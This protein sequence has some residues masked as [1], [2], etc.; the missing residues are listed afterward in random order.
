MMPLDGVRVLDLTRFLSGPYC[1]MTLGDMGAEVVKVERPPGGDDIRKLG[2]HVNGESYCFAMV[3]RNKRSVALDVS[4]DAGREVLLT[5]AKRA[6]VVVENFRPGVTQRLGIDPDTLRAEHPELVHCSITG[7]GQDGPYRDRPG[8]DI[9]AQGICGF[10]RMTGHPG[11]RPAKVGIAINDL[12]AGATAVQAV[13]AAYIHR[14]RTGTGQHIDVSLVDAGLAMTVWEAAAYF[15]SG[16]LP[17]QTGTR[18]RR[19]APYQAFRSADGYVT[20]GG[21]TEAMW[22]ALCLEVLESPQ[23]LA[24]PRYADKFLRL[25]HVDELEADIEQVTSTRTTA[26]WVGRLEAAGVPGG[27]V[28]TYD[29]TLVDEHVLARGAVVEMEHPRMGTIRGL[30]PAARLSESPLSVRTPAPLLGEHTT[31]VLVDHGYR[32]EEISSLLASGTILQADLGA[33]LG[34][35][36]REAIS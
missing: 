18:H 20:V 29:Q 2:P 23:L 7:F 17:A 36:E 25:A 35:P 6:D 4:T 33:D 21:N 5:L 28:L 3:N 14:L 13:L 10:L 16:E 12:V 26:E 24:D 34:A 27:P 11:D 8:F 31:D 9:I 22:R 19:N 1:T 15:G 30:A 32:S